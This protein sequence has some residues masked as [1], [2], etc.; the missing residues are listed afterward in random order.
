MLVEFIIPTYDRIYPLHAMLSSLMA[1]TDDDWSAHVIVDDTSHDLMDSIIAQ[2]NTPKIY[3]TYMDK[4]Y[5]DW[6]HTPRELGK[7]MSKADYVIMTGDDNYYMPIFVEELRKAVNETGADFIYWDMIHSYE[8][9][10]YQLFDCKPRLGEI[11]MG[12]Y[13]TRTWLAQQI[14]LSSSMCADGEFVDEI[15]TKYTCSP[16]HKIN[17]V[18]FVHN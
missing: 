12:A 11:D 8:P 15:R 13:A 5:N 9:F 4:R 6:G 18:L 3:C 1:Q 16:M 17:K 14:H 2:Y 10:R 7:Q